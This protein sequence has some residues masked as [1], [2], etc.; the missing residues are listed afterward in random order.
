MK[1]IILSTVVKVCSYEELSPADRQLTD[2]AREAAKKSYAPYSLFNVGAAVRLDGG[3]I[4]CGSNQENAAYPSGLCAERTTLFWAGA[5]HPDKA[6]E[7]IAIAARDKDGEI[8]KPISPC[9]ACRQVMLETEMRFDRPMRIILYGSR[10]C[11]II[12][13]GTKELMPLSF[14]SDFLK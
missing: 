1:E 4:V 8:E 14:S 2:A 12:K 11:Y 6:V 9:G 13:G 5:Q 3:E 7:A 10:E